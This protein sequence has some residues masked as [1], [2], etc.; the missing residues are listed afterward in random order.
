M[1]TPTCRSWPRP[2]A[3]TGCEVSVSAWD[4]PAAG[5]D[6]VDLAVVRSP[7]DYPV[8]L[9]E[10]RA[11]IARCAKAGTRLANPAEV[12]S[13]NLNKRY[14]KDLA[15]AGV[16]VVPTTTLNPAPTSNSPATASS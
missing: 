13:W 11:W 7:W 9:P 14:L 12:L 2:F 5:W 8:R 16:P 15:D 6:E 10:F 1:K 3:A 4:D